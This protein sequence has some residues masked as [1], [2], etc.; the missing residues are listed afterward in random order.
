M[1]SLFAAMALASAF[2][3]ERTR[4]SHNRFGD[5]HDELHITYR[6]HCGDLPV[7]SETTITLS[8]GG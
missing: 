8:I 6:F 3:G 5:G 4:V 1:R 7:S 2:V